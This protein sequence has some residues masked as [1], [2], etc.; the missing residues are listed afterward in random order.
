MFSLFK[1]GIDF[2][3]AGLFFWLGI[4]AQQNYPNWMANIGS[5]GSWLKALIGKL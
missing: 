1:I 5:A 2:A 4:K 3:M